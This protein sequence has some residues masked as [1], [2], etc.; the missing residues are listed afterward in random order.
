MKALDLLAR[1][2]GDAG[3]GEDSS[4]DS[5]SPCDLGLC[6]CAPP[7]NAAEP[8]D[9]C[10]MTR[11][12]E[13][14]ACLA[15]S[16]VDESEGFIRR[17]EKALTWLDDNLD[18]LLA[19]RLA[20]DAKDMHDVPQLPHGDVLGAGERQPPEALGAGAAH[21][22]TTVSGEA[23]HLF[24]K[25]ATFSRVSG[26][27]PAGD[28]PDTEVSGEHQPQRTL[29]AEAFDEG[30]DHSQPAETESLVA[31]GAIDLQAVA[32]A[33]EAIHAPEGALDAEDLGSS[34][35]VCSA[36]SRSLPK[37]AFSKSQQRRPSGKGPA[38]CT[39]CIARQVCAPS[40]QEASAEVEATS[41]GAD[42]IWCGEFPPRSVTRGTKSRKRTEKWFADHRAQHEDSVPS[43]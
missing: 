28:L 8:L 21:T 34:C 38:R 27:T 4:P 32:S 23:P 13:G 12:G 22:R 40:E 9:I 2:C 33:N 39:E 42:C 19:V 6:A 29:D 30:P 20:D 1:F 36:C 35:L 17:R 25:E 15:G 11:P 14:D 16:V 24:V 5:A 43:G 7:S 3:S 41:N 37:S 10:C 18:N 26:A 31:T